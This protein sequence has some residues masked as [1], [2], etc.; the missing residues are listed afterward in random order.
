MVCP[1]GLETP[2]TLIDATTLINGNPL[3]FI[4]K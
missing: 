3:E 1:G 2:R 4:R